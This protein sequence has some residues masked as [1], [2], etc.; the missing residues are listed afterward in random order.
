MSDDTGRSGL[1]RLVRKR[2]RWI[3]RW[4]MTVLLVIMALIFWAMKN[5]LAP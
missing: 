1:D 2:P 3:I 4:G 5:V